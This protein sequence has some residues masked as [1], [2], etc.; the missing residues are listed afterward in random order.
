MTTIKEHT[1][2]QCEPDS[3]PH[4]QYGCSLDNLWSTVTFENTTEWLKY[5]IFEASAYV[6]NEENY[7]DET[8]YLGWIYECQ[9]CG[10]KIY[11]TSQ[12]YCVIA[13]EVQEQK[14]A[15]KYAEVTA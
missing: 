2:C 5:M 8:R 1:L 13:T 9:V 11:I 14:L 4:T 12:H 15:E 10:D 7:L 6:V 3:Y